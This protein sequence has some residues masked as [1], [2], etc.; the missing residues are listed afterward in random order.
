MKILLV[1]DDAISLRI[2]ETVLQRAGY[3]TVSVGT[4]REAIERLKAEERVGL[5]ISDIM[6]PEMDGLELL[7]YIRGEQRLK[8][9]PVFLCT[10]VDD[11]ERVL[12]ALGLGVQ[13]YVRKPI[14]AEDLVQ[15]IKR[16][17]D[18]ARPVLESERLVESR[19]QIEPETYRLL[20]KELAAGIPP[21]LSELSTHLGAGDVPQALMILSWLRS[22]AVSIGAPRM[23]E[24]LEQVDDE[25]EEALDVTTERLQEH[26]PLILREAEALARAAREA[27]GERPSETG[28]EQPDADTAPGPRG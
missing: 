27:S 12:K 8:D 26:V 19:L 13:G 28:A 9:L 17:V 7:S 2:L 11:R 22:A 5:V 14:R 23:V 4:A 16:V 18:E 20:L 15:K 24:L 3:R 21:K 6:M 1:E 25:F 10:A